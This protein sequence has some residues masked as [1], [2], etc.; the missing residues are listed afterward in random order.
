[1]KTISLTLLLL[2]TISLE[3]HIRKNEE[4]YGSTI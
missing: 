1:M 2:I 3:A 4:W